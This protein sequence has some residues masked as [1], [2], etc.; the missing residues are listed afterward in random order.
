MENHNICLFHSKISEKIILF[1]D[2][3][4]MVELLLHSDLEGGVTI[5]KR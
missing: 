4:S 2:G 3:E 5:Y 1:N